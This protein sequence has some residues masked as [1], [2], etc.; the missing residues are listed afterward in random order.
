M[1][2][3]IER[4]RAEAANPAT[5]PRR[6]ALLASYYQRVAA[7]ARMNPNLPTA[8]HRKWLVE[9]DSNAWQNPATT[10]LLLCGYDPEL[11]DGAQARVLRGDLFGDASDAAIYLVQA[12]WSEEVDGRELA[13]WLSCIRTWEPWDTNASTL[14][15]R[16]TVLIAKCTPGRDAADEQVLDLFERWAWGEDT[17]EDEEALHYWCSRHKF[18]ADIA[19]ADVG[20]AACWYVESVVRRDLGS[21]LKL[22]PI[23]V[24]RDAHARAGLEVAHVIRAA[25][26]ACPLPSHAAQ[27]LG[28][29]QP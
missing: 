9:G 6:L 20:S 24:Q 15:Q 7:L 8:T 14:A 10:P 27:Q 12:W 4:L 11:V 2:P 5:P 3:G 17:D 28:K 23:E 18:A 22:V 1:T 21:D 29:V 26:P 16:L 25:L 19:G 13:T